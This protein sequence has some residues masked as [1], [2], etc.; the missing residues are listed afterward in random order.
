MKKIPWLLALI[1]VQAFAADA[2]TLKKFRWSD[3]SC[4]Y[5][6]VYDARKYSETQL[7]DTIKLFTSA[8]YNDFSSAF[9]ST[10]DKI[11]EVEKLDVATLKREYAAKREALEKLNVIPTPY[12]KEYHQ[13]KLR[14]LERFYDL[15]RVTMLAYK[16]PSVISQYEFAD[17]CVAKYANPLLNGGEDLI[18]IWREVNVESRK[19]NA[20]P[21]RLLRR[22][23][24]QNASPDRFEYAR[25]EVMSFGWWNCANN[26]VPHVPDDGTALAN[27]KKLFRRTRVIECEEP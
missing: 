25:L 11:E 21:E 15:A 19:N 24:E 14:E 26:L 13:K 10:P 20:S 2:Q 17:A 22:F 23:E 1:L 6:S 8:L 4:E 7:K 9:S 12:W 18:K 3:Y 5:E 16:N 27:F